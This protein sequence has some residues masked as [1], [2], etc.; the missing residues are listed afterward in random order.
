M[1]LKFGLTFGFGLCISCRLTQLE[2]EL[3]FELN[4]KVVPIDET[5]LLVKFGGDPRSPEFWP[6]FLPAA[7]GGGGAGGGAATFWAVFHVH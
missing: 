3:A 6:E 7:A 4:Q 5:K 1:D 2:A